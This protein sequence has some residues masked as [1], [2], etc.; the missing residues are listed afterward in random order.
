MHLQNIISSININWLD[1]FLG[2]TFII[3][4]A[5]G[6]MTGFSRAAAGLA[7]VLIGFWVAVNH[8]EFVGRQLAPFISNETG[9]TLLAFFMLFLTIYLAFAIAGILIHGFFKVLSLSWFDKLLGGVL[10]FL[11]AALIGGALIFILTLVLPENNKLIKNSYLYPRVSQVARLM[12]S[13]V[14][15]HLKGRFMWKW[16]RAEKKLIKGKGIA[17]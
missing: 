11:K 15:E 8:Y 2:L 4:V 3:M 17:I 9:R 5:R 10:G 7:G 16:R 12:T 1:L 13:M 14:P 6:I